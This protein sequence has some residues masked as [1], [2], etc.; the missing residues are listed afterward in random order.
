MRDIEF[1][2]WDKERKAWWPLDSTDEL[3]VLNDE[4]FNICQYTGL[5]DKNGKKIFEGDVISIDGEGKYEIRFGT[6]TYDCGVYEFQG[7]YLYDL[8]N[9]EQYENTFWCSE[10]QKERREIIGNR[11]EHPE[12]IEVK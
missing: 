4:A 10:K 5:L 6:G 7:F 12:L 8:E 11:Y 2:A 9:D 1:R 3:G